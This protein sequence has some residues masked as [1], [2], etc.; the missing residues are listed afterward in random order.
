MKRRQFCAAVPAALGVVALAPWR[1]ARAAT[2]TV[3][4]AGLE[5]GTR[6]LTGSEVDELRGALRGELL[7][8]GQD[9]Y[10]AA[11]RLWN[12]AFDRKPALIA[13]C[14]GAADVKQ[15]VSFA[16]AHGVLTAVHG[17]GHS[18]SGQSAWDNALMIDVAPM[19]AVEVDPQ[20][21]RAHVQ[22]GA[23]L[24]Q[25][26]REAQAFGL[27]TTAGTVADTGVA[28]LTLGG[29]VGRIGRRFGLS[30]DNLKSVE[31]VTADGRWQRASETDNPDLFWAVRG[32][33][34]NFGVVTAFDF[35]L[36]EVQPQMYGGQL[37]YRRTNARSLLR[38]FADYLGSA[39]DELYVDLV[40]ESDP[41]LGP[42]AAFDVCY[43]GPL[44]Q[45][46]Q[47]LAGLRKLG[48][49]LRDELGPNTY[50]ALQGSADTP[51]FSKFGVYVKGGLIYGLSPA[52][53]DAVTGLMDAAPSQQMQVWLQHQGG[54]ISRAAPQATAY[55]GRAASHNL[56]LLGAW[57]A[58]SPEAEANKEWVRKAWAQIEPLTRGN[59]VNI[60][61]TDDR[62]SRVRE[63][64]GENWERL[65]QL[66][67][68]YDPANLFRLN[69]NIKP[70]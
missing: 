50:V 28:G 66:K 41:K 7:A 15:A 64:Y 43:S 17:G 25:L 51:G 27:A 39:P 18:L 55:W 68:R 52:L 53:I 45:A 19:R 6:T 20:A 11:R 42:V 57:P 56:G 13:R 69:A 14:S 38:H 26:D 29:G 30:C 58:G 33:G 21:R 47:V 4:L 22:A 70:A 1:L 36:H 16:A 3:T 12:P 5:G 31:L 8:P 37:I 67:R 48:K 2:G 35:Q 23:L 40:L 24:G 59:Y 44:P 65:T 46:E 10:D 61:N 49:P 32:G 9:G 34:G 62:D 63:A 60:A 54:A